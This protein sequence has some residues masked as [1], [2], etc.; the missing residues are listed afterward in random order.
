MITVGSLVKFVWWSDYKAPSVNE[1][2]TG[3]VSWHIVKPGD[4]GIVLCEAEDDFIV[5]LFSNID[6]LLKIHRT[7]LDSI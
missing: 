1:D 3:H 7:M 4:T 2:H 6:S 5:V